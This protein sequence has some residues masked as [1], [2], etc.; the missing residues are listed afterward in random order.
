MDADDISFKDRFKL[1]VDYL[2]KHPEI[3]LIGGSAIV[4]DENGE[5]MGS[6]LKGNNSKG[7][8]KKL[9]KSNP[10]IHPSIMFRNTKEFFYRDKFV[11]SEDYDFYLRMISSRRLIANI[12]DFLIK[13]R[14]SKG[15]FVST[16]PH[17]IFYFNKAREFYFQRR[18]FGRDEYKNLKPP[19]EPSE[20]IDFNKLNSRIK[21]LVKF[22]DNQMRE[23]RKEIRNYFKKY[24]FDKSFVVYYILS[25]LPYS[26]IKLLK[27]LF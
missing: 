22:Q 4:I 14:I 19:K 13:Y 21:I 12:P 20:K 7:V 26:L 25:F 9:L 27:R 5:R 18:K 23:T 3:Y 15:S 24:N 10:L 16:M 11:C 17:Q 1:Q 8:Q 6:L 2:D